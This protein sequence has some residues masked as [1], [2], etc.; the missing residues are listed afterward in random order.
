MDRLGDQRTGIEARIAA[1]TSQMQAY[2]SR[3]DALRASREANIAAAD[4]RV[5]MMQER[6]RSNE[7]SLAAAQAHFETARLNLE[8]QKA[9]LAEGLTST[10]NLEL[11]QLDDA[12]AETGLESAR[13]TLAASQN[14]LKASQAE[15]QRI[16]TDADAL[17]S[18]GLAKYEYAKADVA[19]EKIELAKLQVSMA[20]QSTQ[21]VHAPRDGTI[22]RLLAREGA[23]QVKAGEPLAILVPDT[24]SR[25]VELWVDGNDA[26]LVSEGRHVRLQFEGWPALQFSGWPA[27]AVGTFG[28]TVAFVDATDNGKGKFRVVVVPDERHEQWPSMR[29]LRQGVRANGWVL[30]DQVRLGYELW[31]QFNGFPP[32]V[33]QS[34]PTLYDTK[35]SDKADKDKDEDKDEDKKP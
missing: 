29:F 22:L 19:K 25:A 35:G 11:A 8:R 20:R 18:D 31:R 26:P 5:R 13:A 32:V 28:D 27:V 14:E 15:R 33:A 12:R 23:E 21:A 6:A 4:S 9:L 7:Q 16:Q 17:I 30:L 1:A 3:V 24:T 2:E 34:E 10:R